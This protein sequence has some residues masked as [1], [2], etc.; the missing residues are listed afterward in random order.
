MFTDEELLPIS[1]LQHYLFCPRQTALIHIEQAW[2][3]NRFTAEG[4]VIHHK[5]H[6]SDD[7]SRSCVQITHTLPVVSRRLGIA[8]QCDIVEFHSDGRVIPL[9]YKRGKPK[10]HRADEVQLCAQA[11]CLE[12]MLSIKISESFLFYGQ[13]KRRTV[14]LLDDELRRLTGETAHWLREL[15]LSEITPPAVY[16]KRKCD[17]CSLIDLCQPHAFRLKRGAAA[18]F[19]AALEIEH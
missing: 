10:S 12:E 11:I 6:D 14:V 15:V 17:N 1:A 5:A 4:K 8:G 13:R 19:D 7:E 16:E 9:E 18:W 2:A 3:D